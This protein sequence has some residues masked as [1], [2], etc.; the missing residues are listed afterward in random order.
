MSGAREALPKLDQSI[1]DEFTG[2]Q[3]VSNILELKRADGRSLADH[4]FSTRHIGL[5]VTR[6]A[7]GFVEATLVVDADYVNGYDLKR[8]GQPLK[9]CHGG[10]KATAC[11]T[12]AALAGE[13]LCN[14]ESDVAV[15]VNMFTQFFEPAQVGDQLTFRAVVSNLKKLPTERPEVLVTIT[16]N[17]KQIG[18]AKGEV[19]IVNKV[20]LA[21]SFA[22]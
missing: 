4:N 3:P 8:D 20:K 13:T 22:G 19:A 17:G 10:V 12:V 9:V 2:V 21:N 1:R 5:K 6:A 14:K 15:N 16:R 11:D 18:Y 7:R